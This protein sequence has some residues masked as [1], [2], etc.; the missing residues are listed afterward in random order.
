MAKARYFKFHI[1]VGSNK[2]CISL[3]MTD[4]PPSGHGQVTWLVLYIFGPRPYLWADEAR[5]FRFCLQTEHK[6]VLPLHM[7]KFCSTVVHSGLHNLLKFWEISANISETV[8]DRDT[9][10]MEDMC[11]I[12]LGTCESAVCVRI[13]YE[14]KRE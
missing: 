10:T 12:E 6:R 2:C 13:E 7:L 9:V 11:H 4:Y 1:P 3:V 5:R 14:S 8:Q